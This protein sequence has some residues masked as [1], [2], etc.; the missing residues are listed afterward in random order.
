MLLL[1]KKRPNRIYQLMQIL[2]KPLLTR[3]NKLK[4]SNLPRLS[5]KKRK[6]PSLSYP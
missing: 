5:P 2:K 1:P 4:M 6:W 3:A